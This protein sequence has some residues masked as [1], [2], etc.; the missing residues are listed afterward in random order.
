MLAPGVVAFDHDVVADGE[1]AGRSVDLGPE[2][3]GR[4]HALARPGVQVGDVGAAVGDH[5]R[6]RRGR[7]RRTS[8]PRAG[9]VSRRA[10]GCDRH[11]VVADVR[12]ERLAPARRREAGRA[13]RVPRRGPGGRCRAARSRARAARARRNVPPACSSGSWRWSPTS[14]SLPSTARTCVDEL[15]DL[16]GRDHARP[17]RRRARIAPAGGRAA[18]AQ[19]GEQRERARALD[20]RA[21]LQLGRGAARGR[22]AE[23]R[24][25]G[26]LPRLARGAE[27]ER[28]ARAGP[29]GQHRNPVAVAAEPLDHRAL[30]V[31][32]RRPRRRALRARPCAPS[33]TPGVARARAASARSISSLLERELRRAS[34]SAA[35]A[36]RPATTRPSR[37]RNA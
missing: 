29:A 32:Q 18:R 36:G 17:R 12:G 15:G 5:H 7:R 4:A 31:R 35:A 33:A 20:P 6:R 24:M 14:T 3:A 13:R 34:S 21:V 26:G 2:P 11:A 23:H 28:L 10:V 8:P 9:R 1:R 22:D 30:L 16:A 25:A 19:V 27:R 37:R